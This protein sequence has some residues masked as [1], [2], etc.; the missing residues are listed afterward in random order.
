MIIEFIRIFR[1]GNQW[2]AGIGINLQEGVFGF[3]DSPH[4]AYNDFIEQWYK[5]IGE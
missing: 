4:D 3:G 1:D 5:N 2:C